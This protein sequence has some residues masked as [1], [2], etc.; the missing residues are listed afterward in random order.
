MIDSYS[1]WLTVATAL[2]AGLGAGVYLAFSTF[3]MPG[4]RKLPPAHAIS[5]MS[6]INKAAPSNPPLMLVLFGTGI[7][8]VLVMIAGF[9]H[10]GDRRPSGRSPAPR[11]TWSAC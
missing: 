6:S 9:Q 2:G 4:L 11:C 8:C 5:A 3:V 1:R 7:V 10:K